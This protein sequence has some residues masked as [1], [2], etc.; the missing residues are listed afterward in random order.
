MQNDDN[1]S[2]QEYLDDDDDNEESESQEPREEATPAPSSLTEAKWMLF[3]TRSRVEQARNQRYPE[4]Y[5]R[6]K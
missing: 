3:G 2:D 4:Q 1:Q 6:C 5:S